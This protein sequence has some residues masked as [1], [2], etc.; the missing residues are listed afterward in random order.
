M[1]DIKLIVVQYVEE[2][3]IH[4][5]GRMFYTGD[6]FMRGGTHQKPIWC[7][8]FLGDH[9]EAKKWKIYGGCKNHSHYMCH[10]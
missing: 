6:K 5:A 2:N 3:W 9:S 4:A 10:I 1:T 7:K 8:T